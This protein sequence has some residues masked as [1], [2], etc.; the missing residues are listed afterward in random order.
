MLEKKDW[1]LLVLSAAQGE[2]LSPVQLQKA[3]FLFGQNAPGAIKGP[4]YDFKPYNYGPFDASIYTDAKALDADGLV[5]VGERPGRSWSEYSVTPDGAE[6]AKGIAAE[7]SPEAKSYLET[8]VA[9]VKRVSF[10][11]LL[12]TVYARY[13]EYAV[14]SVFNKR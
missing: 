3:L 13:P 4:F 8:I 1:T 11:D 12:Q 9:W 10:E 7:L 2:P 6:R 14:N 5:F